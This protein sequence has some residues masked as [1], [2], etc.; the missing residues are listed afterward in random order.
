MLVHLYE[1]DAVII[2]ILEWVGWW[3]SEFEGNIGA[4][5][6]LEVFILFVLKT[7]IIA[8]GFLET[9]SVS[10]S[11]NVVWAGSGSFYSFRA[12]DDYHRAWLPWDTQRKFFRKCC[13]R[14]HACRSQCTQ[15]EGFPTERIISPPFQRFWYRPICCPWQWDF[16]W[17]L[18]FC[19][20]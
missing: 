1:C 14:G 8:L 15:E 2:W 7:I 5:L 17:I 18:R 11:E 9:L 19:W 3:W 6:A 13:W 10:F 20:E 16:S 12:E 4:E